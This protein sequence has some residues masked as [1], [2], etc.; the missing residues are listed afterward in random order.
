MRILTRNK[1]I[2]L[3]IAV[4][5]FLLLGMNIGIALSATTWEKIIDFG[6]EGYSETGSAWRT[7]S[8][9]QS[10]NGSY[11]YLSHWDMGKAR[12][13]TATWTTTI[14]QS[15]IYRVAV[16]YRQ[17]ENRSPDAN[18]FATNS[19]GGMDETVINQVGHLAYIWR[20]LGTYRYSEGQVVKVVLDGTDDN[21]SDC[22]DAASWTLLESSGTSINSSSSGTL[23]QITSLLLNNERVALNISKDG[24]GT[25]TIKSIPNALSCGP[26]CSY[27][28]V[29]DTNVILKAYPDR[30][31]SFT[32]WSGSGCSGTGDC[33]VVMDI[34]QTINATFGVLPEEDLNVSVIGTGTVTTSPVSTDGN[35]INCTSGTCTKPYYQNETVTLTATEDR[36]TIFSGWTGDCIPTAN[37]LVTTVNMGVASKTC[38]ATFV[39][40]TQND[41][42]ITLTG[43]GSGTVTSS[44]MSA[45]GN[46]IDC[47]SVSCVKPY[48][49]NDTVTL[50]PVAN[51]D[52]HF[53]EWTGDSDCEDGV[54]TLSTART[55]IATFDLGLVKHSLTVNNGSYENGYGDVST[56][57]NLI[58][59]SGTP[60]TG[61]VSCSADFD[62]NLVVALTASISSGTFAGWS[63][64]C[65]VTADPQVATVIM[66]D[67]KT[68]NAGFWEVAL[69]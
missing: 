49:D 32:G 26:T 22:A 5:T 36:S 25:G 3:I 31:S 38:N 28:F 15:G 11:R 60:G 2:S 67:D 34:E 24:P 64:D 16:S 18:F 41:L 7:Y 43:S 50:T 23:T 51:G 17:T 39:A 66:D 9:P 61:V 63:G 35:A 68:C 42:T 56:S 40:R 47:P 52:S 48:W 8:N 54:V 65:T 13:G 55:C 30:G 14:P 21:Y 6:D 57:P 27:Y 59:C 12:V 44:P 10:H 1:F 62:H 29:K 69:P 33:T 19:S 20:T 58:N 53:V 4:T 45:D 37:P 46:V